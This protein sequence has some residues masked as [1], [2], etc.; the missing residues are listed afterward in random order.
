MTPL[1]AE[2]PLTVRHEPERARFV[3]ALPDGEAE[4]VY[5]PF[6]GD[7]I[8]LQ[9][10]AVPGS[11]QGHGVGDLLVRAALDY[12]RS[13]RVKVIATCPY[14]QAWLRRHPDERP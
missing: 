8:D 13:H 5:A 4:L 1:P 3:V 9:H 7:V 6:G 10:T 11:A 14:V 12:A 2:T